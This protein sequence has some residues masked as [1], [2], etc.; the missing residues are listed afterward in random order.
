MEDLN[1]RDWMPAAD[2]WFLKKDCT[3]PVSDVK[4][5]V[6]AQ[7]MITLDEGFFEDIEFL[8]L[9]NDNPDRIPLKKITVEK[10]DDD[11]DLIFLMK[12]PEV[13]ELTLPVKN[14]TNLGLR[15]L[16]GLTGL[17]KVTFVAPPTS[18]L[19]KITKD[20]LLELKGQLPQAQVEVHQQ[21]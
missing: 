17:K 12:F 4:Q 5:L 18:T 20:G 6:K 1:Y 15:Y 21:S 14:L 8:K 19:I 9:Y 10:I 7:V 3:P 13:E 11:Q 2:L 16:S